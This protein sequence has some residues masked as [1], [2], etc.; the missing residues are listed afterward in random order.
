MH[1]FECEFLM[2]LQ[3]FN[4]YVIPFWRNIVY[5]HTTRYELN[6]SA[7]YNGFIENYIM[8]IIIKKAGFSAT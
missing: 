8:E 4:N 5:F 2:S 1:G 6:I 7:S 3:W